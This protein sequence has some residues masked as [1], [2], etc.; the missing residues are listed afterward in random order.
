MLNKFIAYAHT[1]IYFRVIQTGTMTTDSPVELIYKHPANITVQD[2]FRAYFDS[3]FPD[4]ERV[5]R[6]AVE[7]PELAEAWRIKMI[8]IV[9]RIDEYHKRQ[10]KK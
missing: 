9:H 1:G 4:Q 8:P 7:L 5:L 6:A 3:K 2:L 10:K